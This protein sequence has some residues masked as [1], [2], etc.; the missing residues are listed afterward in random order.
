MDAIDA[1]IFDALSQNARVSFRDLGAAVGLSP[2]AAAARVRRLEESGVIAGYTVVPGAAERA[3][4]REVDHAL[5][6][7]VDVRLGMDTDF[8]AF[9]TRVRVFDYV[10]DVVHM[11]GPFDALIHASLADTAALDA[12][13]SH[14]KRECGAAQTQTRVALRSRRGP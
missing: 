8:A 5:E 10:R 3:R 4:T 2:N 12:F 7:F 11:T 1:A 6:V 9:A 13:L 14:L